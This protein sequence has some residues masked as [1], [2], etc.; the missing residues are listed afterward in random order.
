MELVFHYIYRHTLGRPR[1]L[2]TIGQKLSDLA[3][4][5]RSE[6]TIKR[7]VNLAATDI[8][9]E[10]LNEIRPYMGSIDIED[11]LVPSP[12]QRRVTPRR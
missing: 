5:E 2:M 1:D 11:I 12:V 10:Y 4:E 3:P 7:A 6:V 8:A 9:H